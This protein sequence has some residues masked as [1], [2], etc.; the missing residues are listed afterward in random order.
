L[1]FEEL[2]KPSLK[3]IILAK[4]EKVDGILGFILSFFKILIA[5]LLIA[6]AIVFAL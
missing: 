5:V 4:R 6:L 2:G 1:L 3:F